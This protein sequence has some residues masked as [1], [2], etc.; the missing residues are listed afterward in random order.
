VGF[1]NGSLVRAVLHSH[2]ST[3]DVIHVLHYDL[4]SATLGLND[5]S[6]QALA[7][8]LRDAVIPNFRAL[9]DL[10]WQIQPVIVEQE[11]DPLNANAPRSSWVSGV[12]AAGTRLVSTDSLP[13]GICGVNTWITDHIGRRARGRMFLG[14]TL[15]EGDQ[16]DGTVQSGLLGIWET[17]VASIP[18]APDI[19]TGGGLTDATANLCVYSRTARSQDQDPYAAH[20]KA[21][22]IRTRLHYL[23][24]RGH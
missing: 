20:V 15:A 13:P 3:D 22:I 7:D 16:N 11:K 14:G 23:R 8:R 12:A 10:N 17:F 21:H 1:E 6:H 24:S 18:L 5:N 4:Q 2:R 9:F 19:A